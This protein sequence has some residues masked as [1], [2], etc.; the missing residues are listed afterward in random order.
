VIGGSNASDA[1][2]GVVTYLQFVSDEGPSG[3]SGTFLSQ[4][5]ILTA[6][7]C[8]AD[9]ADVYYGSN[10]FPTLRSAGRAS[11]TRHPYYSEETL[12]YDF[13]LYRLDNPAPINITTLPKIADYSD[14]WGW[15]P[16]RIA[17]AVGWGVSNRSGSYSDYLQ[18]GGLSIV[19]DQT[20][21]AVE[22]QFGK[23]FD[24]STGV[25]VFDSRVA[26]CSGDSGG[27]LVATAPSG[28]S[29]VIG[30]ISYTWSE[31]TLHSVA[32]WTPAAL[33]WIRTV[34]GLA[35]T[36]PSSNQTTI[37]T[38]R[39]F[40]LD[41]YETGSAVGA[42]WDNSATIFVA[43]GANFPD[44]LAAG[45]A[46]ARFKAPVL[47]VEKSFVPPSTRIEIERL[48]P[49]R[50][51]VVGGP[52]A[53]ED[54]VVQTL[55]LLSSAIVDRIGGEDRYDTARRLTNFAWPTGGDRPI[56]VASGRGFQDPLVASAAAAVY[57][58]PFVL[59]DGQSLLSPQQ[60]EL[61]QRL[62]PK[63]I[64]I[65]GEPGAFRQD[66]IDQLSSMA[67]LQIFG[68]SDVSERSSKVWYWLTES[69]WAS[70]ATATN[71][72]DALAAVPFSS[73]E[74]VAPL[75]LIPR[76]CVPRVVMDEVTRLGIS[77]LALFGGP[78]AISPRVENLEAC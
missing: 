19:S 68:D 37:Q 16:G 17:Y 47:L 58:E 14:S 59:L 57:G 22:A 30:V 28:T 54:S 5:W 26:A 20:C 1:W 7:H 74:P 51:V 73:L 43:T 21:A 48:Q 69:E 63:Y 24:A 39:V 78:S 40:G 29:V 32:A 15:T 50:I 56:W 36:S 67:Q 64:S 42:L 4:T 72:A 44:S 2:G 75:M 60:T 41:R 65:I 12:R 35:L 38:V 11:G 45:A 71:F 8:I 6:G 66:L 18:I 33:A 46:A 23:A 62:R 52:S 25:C 61:I 3:C 70:F 27:P 49:S 55:R 53:I 10:H 77:R 34:T 13:G 31:C 76:D 9:R